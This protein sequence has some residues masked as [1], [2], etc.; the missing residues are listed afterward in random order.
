MKLNTKKDALIA[1]KDEEIENLIR[2]VAS[3]RTLNAKLQQVPT[4]DV[5][6]ALGQ[7][8][9]DTEQRGKEILELKNHIK[10]LERVNRE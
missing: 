5:S 4:F 9:S 10:W 6:F 3:L 7:A 1:K 8:K 2:Q